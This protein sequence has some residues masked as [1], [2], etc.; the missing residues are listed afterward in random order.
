LARMVRVKLPGTKVVFIAH[1][2]NA[3]YTEG[4]GVLLPRPLNPKPAEPEPINLV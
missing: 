4:L 1:D 2:K 3:S